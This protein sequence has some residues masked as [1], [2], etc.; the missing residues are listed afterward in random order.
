M[1]IIENGTSS[2]SLGHFE[3][4]WWRRGGGG[5]RRGWMAEMV[6]VV[7][8]KDGSDAVVIRLAHDAARSV[9]DGR[10]R[11]DHVMSGRE[12]P[13]GRRKGIGIVSC[14]GRETEF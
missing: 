3:G 12:A 9:G 13:R 14:R 10:R 6:M 8:V 7:V 2:V 1:T 5:G 4:R 11:L